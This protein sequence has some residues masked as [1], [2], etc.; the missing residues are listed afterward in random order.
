[1]TGIAD[2][3]TA[4]TIR[5]QFVGCSVSQ[6]LETVHSVQ[7]EYKGKPRHGVAHFCGQ[8]HIFWLLGFGTIDSFIAIGDFLDGTIPE[9][10]LYELYP[11]NERSGPK[12][13]RHGIFYPSTGSLEA[14]DPLWDRVEWK[15]LTATERIDRLFLAKHF[16]D[17]AIGLPRPMQFLVMNLYLNDADLEQIR[18]LLQDRPPH[19]GQVGRYER[20]PV[21]PLSALAAGL[22]DTDFPLAEYEGILYR[23]GELGP[24]EH[25]D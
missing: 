14:S 24:G 2:W 11:V 25:M 1:M 17:A 9:H 21:F 16:G 10:D 4:T 18:P 23:Y 19:V 3:F 7:G 13:V 15:P 8:P 5:I 12:T 6:H 22:G 20:I